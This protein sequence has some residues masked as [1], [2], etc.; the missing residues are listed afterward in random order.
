MLEDVVTDL[1]MP[2]AVSSPPAAHLGGVGGPSAGAL[3]LPLCAGALPSLG[4]FAP[5][6]SEAGFESKCTGTFSES[7]NKR[8]LSL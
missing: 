4:F 3:A 6:D 2:I 1:A 8:H 7:K 5:V